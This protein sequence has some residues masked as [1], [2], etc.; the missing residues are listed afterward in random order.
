VTAPVQVLV[1]G[2][3]TPSFSSDV[4]AELDVVRQSG[5]VRLLDLL[6]VRRTTDGAF[7]TLDLAH[8]LTTAGLGEVALALL[9][10]PG[11][12]PASG[13][14]PE[15]STLTAT[16]RQTKAPWSLEDAVPPG[17]TAAVALIEHTWAQPLAAAI[18]SA[19]GHWLE[20]TWLGASDLDTLQGLLT[21]RSH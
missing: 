15:A 12:A 20:E 13:G 3:D 1:I 8:D 19:G 9:S 18:K 2:F 4:L 6:L 16:A 17:T 7:E 10:E 11:S 21:G 14:D 5:V